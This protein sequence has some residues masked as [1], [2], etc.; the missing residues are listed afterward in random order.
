[1]ARRT[2]TGQLDLVQYAE[3]KGQDVRAE[4]AA[5]IEALRWALADLLWYVHGDDSTEAQSIKAHAQELLERRD[6]PC[7]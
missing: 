5:Y 7:A 1:M 4:D 2:T 3:A 6:E